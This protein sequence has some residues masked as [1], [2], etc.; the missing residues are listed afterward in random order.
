MEERT[1]SVGS[2]TSSTT[3]QTDLKGQSVKIVNSKGEHREYGV[4]D[5]TEKYKLDVVRN[6]NA[7]LLNPYY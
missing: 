1:G 4:G 3:T 5:K 7:R 2:S 6:T